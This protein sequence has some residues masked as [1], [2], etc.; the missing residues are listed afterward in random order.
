MKKWNLTVLL[1]LLVLGGLS[2]CAADG[3]EGGRS[4]AFGLYDQALDGD[5]VEAS[6]PE[7]LEEEGETLEP[8]VETAP[9]RETREDQFP[10]D[11]GMNQ[12]QDDGET[13]D[14]AQP[15]EL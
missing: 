1:A 12:N 2:G 5:E 8:D 3:L 9:D 14:R 7:D 10:S 13:R 11:E 4:C 15:K 6:A